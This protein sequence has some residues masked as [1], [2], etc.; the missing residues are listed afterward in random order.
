MTNDSTKT[1]TKS[2]IDKIYEVK[3]SLLSL[4]KVLRSSNDGE[5]SY[6]NAGCV[7]EPIARML[8]D[9][10]DAYQERVVLP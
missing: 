5:G 10:C 6:V 3:C 2:E 4:A 8:A 1:F 9:V 7:L